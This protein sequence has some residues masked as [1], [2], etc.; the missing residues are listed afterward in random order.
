VIGA[1][2]GVIILLATAAGSRYSDWRPKRCQ[3]TYIVQNR[4]LNLVWILQNL[5]WKEVRRKRK[6][7][8]KEKPCARPKPAPAHST[9]THEAQLGRCVVPTPGATPSATALCFSPLTTGTHSPGHNAAV[10][11]ALRTA[12][13]H[14]GATVNPRILLWTSRAPDIWPLRTPEP[15]SLSSQSS[16]DEVAWHRRNRA[17][18]RLS[19]NAIPCPRNQLVTKGGWKWCRGEQVARRGSRGRRGAE[20]S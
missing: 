14:A 11:C 16:A 9:P 2:K 5:I 18:E 17:G 12:R 4:N 15:Y 8:E 7:K 10:T 1:R 3:Q 20:I 13:A 19:R 6:T